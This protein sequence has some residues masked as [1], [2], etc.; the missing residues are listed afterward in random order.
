MKA[1]IPELVIVAD[2]EEVQLLQT[3]PEIRTQVT[4]TLLVVP[5]AT[6]KVDV[7]VVAVHDVGTGPPG[8][9]AVYLEGIGGA[10]RVDPVHPVLPY[11]SYLV[12]VVA[13]CAGRTQQNTLKQ[14]LRQNVECTCWP[15]RVVY[16]KEN[17]AS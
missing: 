16:T 15:V 17:D 3:Q 9:A 13:V 12:V 11:S 6:R 10:S 5:P 8:H 14:S 1:S 7:I 2:G 4:K